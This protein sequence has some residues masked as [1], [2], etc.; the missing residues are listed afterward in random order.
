M[1]MT[2]LIHG[3]YLTLSSLIEKSWQRNRIVIFFYF[4]SSIIALNR[5]N[6][7]VEGKAVKALQQTHHSA[8]GDSYS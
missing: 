8:S 3:E 2:V 5:N 1:N 4:E 6:G 7:L